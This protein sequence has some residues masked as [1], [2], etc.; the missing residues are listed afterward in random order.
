M[1]LACD[2]ICEISIKPNM[3]MRTCFPFQSNKSIYY[4][5]SDN[6]SLAKFSHRFSPPNEPNK[7]QA[8]NGD[9][10][11]QIEE[12]LLPISLVRFSIV[13]SS[14]LLPI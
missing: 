9:K 12:K 14:S 11:K 1:L 8:T 5:S 2:Q 13:T 7:N 3:W 10:S 6:E 4:M